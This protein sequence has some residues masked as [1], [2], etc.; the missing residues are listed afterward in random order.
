MLETCD[1]L[2]FSEILLELLFYLSYSILGSSIQS[3][4]S[5][6]ISWT[7]KHEMLIACVLLVFKCFGFCIKSACSINIESY[8]V[9]SRSTVSSM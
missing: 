1:I 4:C 3:L 9:N 7:L 8:S 5:F 2:T 6:D